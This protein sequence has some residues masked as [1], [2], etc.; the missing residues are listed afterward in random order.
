MGAKKRSCALEKLQT[1]F[2][3]GR[4]HFLQHTRSSDGANQ[5][6]PKNAR[7]HETRDRSVCGGVDSPSLV[8][9]KRCQSGRR[10]RAAS[11]YLQP[12][13]SHTPALKQQVWQCC[14][15]YQ[16]ALYYESV[17]CA[18]RA[19]Y[20][21]NESTGGTCVNVRSKYMYQARSLILWT[22]WSTASLGEFISQTSYY[23]IIN[24]TR[25]HARRA[26]IF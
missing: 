1:D 26:N 17:S 24:S 7:K 13:V 25:R 18:K 12:H 3:K 14:R 20:R 8:S 22:L 21:F 16:L 19:E 15:G 23:I 2:R 9:I 10:C 11:W 5:A 6:K 4:Q